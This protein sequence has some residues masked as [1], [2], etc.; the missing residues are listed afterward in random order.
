MDNHKLSPNTGNK[1]FQITC[2]AAAT[3]E[4]SPRSPDYRLTAPGFTEGLAFLSTID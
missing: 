4:N 2:F 1:K 3:Q